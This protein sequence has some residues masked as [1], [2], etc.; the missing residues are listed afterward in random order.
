MSVRWRHCID[1][2]D[3]KQKPLMRPDCLLRVVPQPT[4][5]RLSE[6]NDRR[7]STQLNLLRWRPVVHWSDTSDHQAP[8]DIL[9]GENTIEIVDD[10][11]NHN[12]TAPSP[13]VEM[14]AIMIHSVCIITAKQSLILVQYVAYINAQQYLHF[15]WSDFN[16]PSISLISFVIESSNLSFVKSTYIMGAINMPSQPSGS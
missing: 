13:E 8:S 10:Y 16:L 15:F 11:L 7:H 6:T 3:T 9:I 12:T 1:H 4:D 14:I 2:A 5:S